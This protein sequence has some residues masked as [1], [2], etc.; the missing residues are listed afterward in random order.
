MLTLQR[1]D[2][3][4]SALLGENKGIHHGDLIC[5]SLFAVP[6]VLG[7]RKVVFN[8]F[9]G[10]CIETERFSWFEKPEEFIYD[11]EDLE[12]KDLIASD[13][14]VAANLDEVKRYKGMLSILRRMEK[15]VPGYRGYT[16]LPTTACNA[17][18]VYCFEAGLK[19]ETMSDEVVEQTIRYI[20]AT[21]KE[22]ERIRL[23][24]FGGEPL[25]GEKII[26][27]IC[28]AMREAGVK[29]ISG[30]ISNGSL[31]TEE[32]AIKAKEDWHLS[33]V[34]ITLDGRENVYCERKRY[35]SFEGS[36]Y[37]AVLDGIHAMLKQ[38]IRVNIRLNIDEEN[39]DE[40][41]A[42]AD[43]MESEF[44]NESMISMYSH[45]I[46]DDSDN[47]HGNSEELYD[48]MDKLEERLE[49]FNRN[50]RAKG[51]PNKNPKKKSR[52]YYDRRGS[53]KR[54]YCMVD[55]PNSGPVILPSGELNLCEHIGTIP[56][57]YTIFDTDSIDRESYIDRNRTEREECSHCSLLPVCTDF[58]NC[59][60]KNRDCYREVLASEKRKI[61]KLE[62]ENRIPPV[63]MKI[64][65]M[66][67][68]VKE[69]DAGFLETNRELV[70]P[71]YLKPD[72]TVGL[73][74][75][76]EILNQRGQED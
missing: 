11:D 13:Y 9:T 52:G 5:P 42:L 61:L 17:R 51:K 15:P 31:M 57:P 53:L 67:I 50:R 32:L 44:E 30:M 55:N 25:L 2:P 6:F 63:N 45:G 49:Q 14:L 48:A 36:P 16:I 56:V 38:N 21:K 68:R 71:F 22:G 26:D 64:D 41:M 7:E 29:Y 19:Y 12:I 28:L 40:M 8:T 35:V 60:T 66:I 34:Q 76:V 59:P 72:R 58:S 74:D 37:R 46:F 24:W 20:L 65:D 62:H 43:E 39:V 27:R 54:Y 4:V 3:K 75:A 69:P 33:N 70:V 1:P 23:S 10:Q 47:P 73:E 18:C